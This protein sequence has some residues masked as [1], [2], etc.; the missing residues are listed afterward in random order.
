MFYFSGKENDDADGDFSDEDPLAEDC[1]SGSEYQPSE[2][3]I[4]FSDSSDTH[5]SE[6]FYSDLSETEKKLLDLL[7]RVEIQ[8]KFNRAVPILLT[9][10]MVGSI[11]RLLAMRSLLGITSHYLFVTP[12]DSRPFR[13]SQVLHDFAVRA[14]V[15][16][17]SIFTATSLRKQTA[18]LSQAMEISKYDQDALAAFLGHDLRIHRGVYCHQLPVVQKTK[19]AYYLLKINRGIRLTQSALDSVNLE[20]VELDPEP[21][22]VQEAQISD[23][24]TEDT[25]GDKDLDHSGEAC[26]IPSRSAQSTAASSENHVF[27]NKAVVKKRTGKSV[28]KQPWSDKEMEALRRLEVIDQ[29]YLFFC[30]RLCTQ[31]L[32]CF[33]SL[34]FNSGSDARTNSTSCF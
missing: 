20:E 13:G 15:S 10:T 5:I 12:S 34:A 9:P 17:P 25:A 28:V 2:S 32:T 1:M 14:Q 30:K 19:V 18:T 23:S 6:E 24:E 26:A 7:H 29:F 16:D 33:Q 11:E 3:D 21:V 27:V 4:L 8:G 31:Y 22:P